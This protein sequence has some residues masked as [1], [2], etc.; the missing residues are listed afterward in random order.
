MKVGEQISQMKVLNGVMVTNVYPGSREHLYPDTTYWATRVIWPGLIADMTFF[1][2]A[3]A[4]PFASRRAFRAIRTTVRRT[5][6]HCPACGFDRRG[7]PPQ[8]ACPEFIVA[9][10][11]LRWRGAHSHAPSYRA[12]RRTRGFC[13]P[14]ACRSGR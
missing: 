12:K 9:A 13:A 8:A 11:R 2:S 7:L 6:G 5:K 10:S 4:I 3:F 1:A 14:P